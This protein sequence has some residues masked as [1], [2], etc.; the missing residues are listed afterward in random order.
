MS[1]GGEPVRRD[2]QGKSI[3]RMAA[4]YAAPPKI[5]SE[6]QFAQS[7]AAR[8]SPEFAGVDA[9]SA[10]SGLLSQPKI[11]RKFYSCCAV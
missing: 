1:W 4:V 2:Q 6:K 3:I 10:P 8:R 11:L 5:A 7:A 9:V